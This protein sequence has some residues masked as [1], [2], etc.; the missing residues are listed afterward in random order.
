MLKQIRIANSSYPKENPFRRLSKVKGLVYEENLSPENARKLHEKEVDVALIPASHFAAHGGYV[1]LDFGVVHNGASDLVRLYAHRPVENLR[2]IY[3][4]DDSSSSV[5][6]LRMLLKQDWKTEPRI[7]RS[8]SDIEPHSL[9]ADEGILVRSNLYR[10]CDGVFGHVVDLVAR[11]HRLTGEPFVFMLWATRPGTL[12]LKQL[13]ALNDHFHLAIRSSKPDQISEEH[14]T[15]STPSSKV[16][17]YFDDPI[18]Q[19]LNRQFEHAAE[20]KIMPDAAYRYST[21]RLLDLK[22]TRQLIRRSVKDILLDAIDGKRLNV[23]ETVRLAEEASV[24]DLGVA[25]DMLRHRIR[26]ERGLSYVYLASGD[27]KQ[28]GAHMKRAISHKAQRFLILPSAGELETLRDLKETLNSLK[29]IS[30]AIEIEGLGVPHIIKVAREQG[31]DVRDVVALLVTAGLDA[32]PSFGGGLLID[33]YMQERKHHAYTADDWL[34]VMRWGHRCGMKS[35]CCLLLGEEESWEDRVIHLQK[36]RS[37]QDETAGFRFFACQMSPSL[38]G[39]SDVTLKLRATAIARLFV[40]NVPAVVE[41]E[42]VTDPTQ[43][44]LSLCF[45]GGQVRLQ[46]GDLHKEVVL[47]TLGMFRELATSGFDLKPDILPVVEHTLSGSIH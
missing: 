40:D 32:I 12:S 8:G 6:L 7:V 15:D 31:V 19:A 24:A 33:R 10:Q 1:G 38:E 27:K 36:L 46:V 47:S 42:T 23:D 16:A 34:S 5:M 29:R 26:P 44:L 43:A 17:L 11:W 3:V 35:S 45:G 37:L 30:G 20:L 39:A 14:G 22:P 4:H 9:Q 18:R 2:T 28:L 21:Y 13:Q 25:A 41:T